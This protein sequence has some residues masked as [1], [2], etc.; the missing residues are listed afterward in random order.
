M[1]IF[2]PNFWNNNNLIT[3][4]LLPLTIVTRIYVSISKNKTQYQSKSKSICV[5]N[6]YL[7]GTGKTQLVMKIDELL[8]K[9][10][11]TFV[12]KKNYEDQIDEQELLKK[13]SRVLITKTRIEGIKK[14]E[15]KKNSVAIFDD[16]LQDR[17]LKFSLTIVC[18]SSIAGIGNGKLLPAGPL[19]ESL[20][21]LQNYD[22]VFINGKIN[23][24]LLKKIRTYNKKIKVFSGNYILKNK[25]N[26]SK[27]KNY[28]AFCGIGTPENFFTFLKDNK[29]NIKKKIIFPDH[30]NYKKSDIDELKSLA[31]QNNLKLLTTE[32]DFIKVNK[33][34]NFDVK[35]TEVDLKINKVN[36]F[37]KFIM[38]YL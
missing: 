14:I 12:V 28:L 23:K 29:I 6:I 31:K 22:A 16:G 32:K 8:K 18:F 36:N 38:N 20:F 33:F 10:R 30:Y 13:N 19:R 17:S 37:V 1:K 5:G 34:K 26:F 21:E 4:L 7:G 25:K 11:R 35:K 9:K 3:Y 15:L 24:Y 2:K 27:N